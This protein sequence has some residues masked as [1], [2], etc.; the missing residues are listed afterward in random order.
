VG[1]GWREGGEAL[2]KN[3]NRP[4]PRITSGEREERGK[5]DERN[6]RDEKKIK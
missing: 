1:E 3:T 6:G 2:R 4:S 5:F